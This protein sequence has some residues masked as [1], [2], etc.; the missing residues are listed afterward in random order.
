MHSFASAK[1][2]CF[3]PK[4]RFT[5]MQ[6]S[7]VGNVCTK[8]RYATSLCMSCEAHLRPDWCEQQCFDDLVWFQ[9]RWLVFQAED[10]STSVHKR[11][12]MRALTSA[13]ASVFIEMLRKARSLSG[14][15][16]VCRLV[17]LCFVL[18][19]RAGCR[20]ASISMHID[21]TRQI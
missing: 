10:V 17:P 6:E 15:R 8:K 1:S 2:T 13:L 16:E 21:R 7:A 19:C 3:L 4:G 11:A 18:D 5:D 12:L 9:T 20:Q 14:K